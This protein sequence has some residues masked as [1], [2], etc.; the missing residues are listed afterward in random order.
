M[1]DGLWEFT[2]GPTWLP[3]SSN[4]LAFQADE[5]VQSDSQRHFCFLLLQKPAFTGVSR[6]SRTQ[7]KVIFLK[8][9]TVVKLKEIY[10]NTYE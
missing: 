4:T 7:V 9:K 6:Q 3:A 1:L 5:S 10:V 8:T 2:T